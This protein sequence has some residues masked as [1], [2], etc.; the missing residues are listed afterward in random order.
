MT[1]YFTGDKYDWIGREH[2]TVFGMFNAVRVS[3]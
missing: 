1:Q 2:A 3:A